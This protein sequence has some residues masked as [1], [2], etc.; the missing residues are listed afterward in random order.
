MARDSARAVF[1]DTSAIVAFF[2]NEPRSEVLRAFWYLEATKYTSQFCMYESLNIYKSKWRS[3]KRLT[4]EQ[5]KA[6]CFQTF[7]WY[8]ASVRHVTD[9]DFHDPMIF[10]DV[11]LL[12]LKYQ[13]DMSDAFQILCVQR[14]FFSV[15]VNDSQTI[16]V[17]GDAELAKAARDE[18]LKAWDFRKEDPPV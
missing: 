12:A 9:L 14:G 7:H 10:Q 8:Q 1:L 5:Y 16:L 17:T 15:L 4:Y 6:A 11:Y 2:T 3:Q 18:G 13:L